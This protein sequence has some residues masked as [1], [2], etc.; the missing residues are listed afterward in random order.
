[1]HN[2]RLS[3]YRGYIWYDSAH[4]TTITTIILQSN[5]HSWTTP[6]TSYTSPLQASYGVSFVSYE[7]KNDTDISRA[8]CTDHIGADFHSWK[9]PHTWPLRVSYGVSFVSYK[10]KNDRYIS[11]AH[12]TEHGV[13][14]VPQCHRAFRISFGWFNIPPYKVFS[15]GFIIMHMSIRNPHWQS[16][17]PTAGRRC[18]TIHVTCSG[19]LRKIL[20]SFVGKQIPFIHFDWWQST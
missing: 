8:R 13:A 9:T 12:C 2:T 4:S 11:R 17:V 20:I 10:T 6:Y 5:F 19:F 7:N 1:M 15:R 18:N 3:I 16:E 14:L